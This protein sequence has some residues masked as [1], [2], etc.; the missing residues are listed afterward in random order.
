MAPKSAC[1]DVLGTCFD[2]GA[3]ADTI[4]SRLGPQLHDLNVDAKTLTFMWFFA[5]QRDFAYTSVA[6]SYTPIAKILQ[7]TFKRACYLVDVPVGS[8]SDDDVAAVM[9]TMKAL[10]P[11]NGLKECFDGLR[12]KGW[13]VYGVTNGAKATSLEYYRLAKID[14]DA[15]HLLSCDEIQ[16]AKPDAKVYE[17]THRHLTAKG[18]G[19]GEGERWFVA[20]HAWDLLAARKAGFKTA[21]LE[22]EEHDAVEE[23]FGKF[24][25]YAKDFPE[26]LEKMKG[27]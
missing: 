3:A 6:G 16:V 25:L 18:A 10:P 7:A 12:E 2:F 27:L 5:A 21:F 17:N 13:D 22:H 26:L 20:A 23:V 11:R 4:H 19:A 8:V 24:D 1:F 15:E 9:A 14:L